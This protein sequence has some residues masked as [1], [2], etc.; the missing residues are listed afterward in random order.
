LVE[1]AARLSDSDP[2]G[3][4]P[5]CRAYLTQ[6]FALLGDPVAAARVSEATASARPSA[7]RVFEPETVLAGAWRAAVEH[8]TAEAGDEALRA[9]SIAAGMDQRAVEAHA[10]HTAVRFGRA[11]DV[12]DQLQ[13]LANHVDGLAPLFAAHADA[14]ARGLGDRLDDVTAAFETA[15]AELLAAEAAAHAAEAHERDGHRRRATASAAR[16]ARLARGCGVAATPALNR[17][18]PPSLTPREREVAALAA[19]GLPSP[20]IARQLVISVRTVET[21]LTNAFGKLGIHR[22]AE[23][24]TALHANPE[25]SS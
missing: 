6:A 19:A 4:L 12:T 21:H 15:G 16:S 17:A 13:E 9:A 2:I 24:G 11:A 10:L 18:A 20:E 5:L 8:R 25:L 7:V 23:L 22:R 3:C 14:V 1:A